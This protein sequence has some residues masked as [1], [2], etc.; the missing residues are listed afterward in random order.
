MQKVDLRHHQRI[1]VPSGHT[2]RIHSNGAALPFEG[3]VT[4]IGLGGMFIRIPKG[5]TPGTVLKL[6]LEDPVATFES[7]CTVRHVA[8]NGVGVEITAITPENE[9]RLRALLLRL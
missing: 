9:R 1:L 4:V 5:P 3:L 7:E 2:M 6:T 8:E